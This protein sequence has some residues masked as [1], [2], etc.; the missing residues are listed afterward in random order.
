MEVL[1]LLLYIHPMKRSGRGRVK[2]NG[3]RASRTLEA[4]LPVTGASNSLLATGVDCVDGKGNGS[5]DCTNEGDH[6]HARLAASEATLARLASP[7]GRCA[8]RSVRYAT[9]RQR[10]PRTWASGRRRTF[11]VRASSCILCSVA[12]RRFSKRM[13]STPLIT[14]RIS[15]R[16]ATR[17]QLLGGLVAVAVAEVVAGA[18][19]R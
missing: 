15:P 1:L 16:C 2:G 7:P 6:T 9:R 10:W 19:D 13:S 14:S 11:G 18:V 4:L 5:N 3:D 12:Q 8:M 17:V